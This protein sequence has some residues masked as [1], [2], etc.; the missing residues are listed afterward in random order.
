MMEFDFMIAISDGERAVGQVREL[1]S[2]G[3]PVEQRPVR[4][5]GLP[6]QFNCAPSNKR[7]LALGTSAYVVKLHHSPDIH[8]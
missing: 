7:S 2:R 6:A 8:Q 5:R 3:N 4:Q 1:N